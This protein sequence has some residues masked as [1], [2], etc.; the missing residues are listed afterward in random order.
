MGYFPNG[1]AGAAYEATY[2]EKCKHYGDGA[3]E[4]CR[5]WMVQLFYNSEQNTN[6]SVEEILGFLIPLDGVWNGE[7]TMFIQET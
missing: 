2:C 7:C 6:E 3:E 4:G 1:T 5:V